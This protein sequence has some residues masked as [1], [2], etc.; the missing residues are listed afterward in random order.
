MARHLNRT[1]E[2]AMYLRLGRDRLTDATAIAAAELEQLL[3]CTGGDEPLAAALR[4]AAEAAL[5][6]ANQPALDDLIAPPED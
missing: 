6:E 4:A 3:H 1:V 5:E 2:R